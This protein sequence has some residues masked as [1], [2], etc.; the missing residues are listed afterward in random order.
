MTIKS[1]WVP[2]GMNIALPVSEY[3]LSLFKVLKDE[4]AKKSIKEIFAEIKKEHKSAT[5]K[6]LMEEANR[7]FSIFIDAGVMLLQDKSL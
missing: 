5:D 1:V 3:T 2:E 7:V 4:T 6:D